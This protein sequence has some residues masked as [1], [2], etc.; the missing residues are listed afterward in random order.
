MAIDLEALRKTHEKLIKKQGGNNEDFLAKFLQI[1]DGE[2][3]IRILPWMN[4]DQQFYAET[5]L[6]RI[7]NG[8]GDQTRNYHCPRVLGDPC[9]ICEV[10]FGLWKTGKK[11]DEALARL[12][13]PRPRYYLNVLDRATETVKILSVGSIL[14][15]KITSTILDP[16][17]GDITDPKNGHDFKIVKYQEGGWPKYD[18][19]APRPKS[20]PLAKNDNAI[21]GIL[22]GMHEIHKLVT[23]EDNETLKKVAQAVA[24]NGF[25]SENANTTVSEGS[26]PAEKVEEKSDDSDP[27]DEAEN[28]LKKLRVKEV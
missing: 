24:I 13:K 18:Q 1:P 28:Y 11:E 16:D 7:P 20:T 26:K 25:Y 14:F 27:G 5:S 10:Y 9:P 8:D 22:E 3:F 19:S 4:E 12:I 23:I 17:Y 2:T 15:Q 21:A 6:H